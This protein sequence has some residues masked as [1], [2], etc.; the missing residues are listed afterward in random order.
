MGIFTKDI[1][2]M[3]DLFLHQ[4]EDIY[5]AEQQLTKAIPTMA[6][7]TATSISR[8]PADRLSGGLSAT[9]VH[10]AGQPVDS[11]IY[12]A[13]TMLQ[14]DLR[15]GRRTVGTETDARGTVRLDQRLR[16]DLDGIDDGGQRLN[17]TCRGRCVGALPGVE[18]EFGNAVAPQC[19]AAC[20][21]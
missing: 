17:P 14:Q 19:L 3:E 13:A 15:L 21:P 2:S 11:D 9:L 4:L 1:K 8:K 12:R 7:A 20:L 18:H 5:Y 6:S 16:S 10:P